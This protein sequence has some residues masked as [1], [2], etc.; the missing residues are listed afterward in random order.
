M[1]RQPESNFKD[2]VRKDL[3]KL[4]KIWFSK[5]QQ[6]SIRGVP[7]FLVCYCGVF[8]AIEL[9]KDG[10]ASVEELQRYNVASIRAAGG[11][12]F[13]STPETWP[14]DYELIKALTSLKAW[15]SVHP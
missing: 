5:I 8:I 13:I 6:V 9:K 15:S 11:M 14:S 2:R 10:K 12:A 7:D 3:Q 4:K 1:A